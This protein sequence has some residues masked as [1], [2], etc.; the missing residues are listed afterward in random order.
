[1]KTNLP[2]GHLRGFTI[3]VAHDSNLGIGKDGGMPWHLPEDLRNFREVTSKSSN[4]H[5]PV[6]IMG[7]GT[8]ESI[9]CRP[10]PGRTN[11]VVSR[12][13][14]EIPEVGNCRDLD[15]AITSYC[16]WARGG[17]VYIIGGGS[18]YEQALRHPALVSLVVTEIKGDLACDTFMADYRGLPGLKEESATPW[19]TSEKGL[20]YRFVTYTV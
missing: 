6:V 18:V 4:A 17:S 5:Q 11:V 16:S 7:H 19:K 12:K 1:M 2:E 10:L 8:W 3:V 14:R 13:N 9:G 20:E 15:K